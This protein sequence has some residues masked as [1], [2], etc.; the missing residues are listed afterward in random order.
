MIPKRKMNGK[1]HLPMAINLFF[2]K[3]SEETFT[4]YSNS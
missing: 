4:M 2:S 1:T 3:D